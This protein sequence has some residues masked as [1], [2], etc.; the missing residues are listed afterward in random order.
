MTGLEKTLRA[1]IRDVPD[2]PKKG[3]L[4]KDITPLLADAATLDRTCAVLETF[5]K[6]VG[7]DVV[8]GIES[9]GFIFGSILAARLG[10]SFVP[11]RKKDKL[12]WKTWRQS[13]ALEYG[14]ATIEMHR[15]AVGKGDRVLMVDDL[16]ATGGTMAAAC[17]LVEKGGAQVAGAAFVIELN[18]LNGRRK[19]KGRN[20]FS[21]I[22]Y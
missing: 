6:K 5:A 13:Y 3:I 17:K 7:T 1:R 22:G 2:F 8:A 11:I 12:P 15:D 20:V 16:L 14:R 18:F 10:A 9:R 19:L 21:I 4:F